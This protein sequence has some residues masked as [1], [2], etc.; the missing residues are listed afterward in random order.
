M[1]VQRVLR[2]RGGAPVLLADFR[3]DGFMAAVAAVGDPAW[4]SR[5]ERRVGLRRTRSKAINPAWLVG[6]MEAQ[7]PPALL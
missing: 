6:E 7:L 4:G 3:N 5:G 2:S 1:G